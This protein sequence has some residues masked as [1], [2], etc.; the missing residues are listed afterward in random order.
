MLSILETEKLPFI[1]KLISNNKY[2]TA[3]MFYNYRE[4]FYVQEFSI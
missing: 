2:F 4:Q 3:A 1:K